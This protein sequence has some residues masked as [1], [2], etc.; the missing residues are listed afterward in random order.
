MEKLTR[1]FFID[2]GYI[3]ARQLKDGTWIG[4]L[5]LYYTVAI[6]TD[7]SETGLKNR[8]C[9]DD[10]AIALNQFC[11]MDSDECIPLGYIAKRVRF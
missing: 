4:L 2:N 10:P 7:L 11:I 3:E 5:E 1:T 9:F 6:C 8:Y